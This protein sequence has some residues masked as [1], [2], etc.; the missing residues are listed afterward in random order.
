MIREST[1][2]IDHD[3]SGY[4]HNEYTGYGPP[5]TKHGKDSLHL[6]QLLMN[7]KM[8]KLLEGVAAHF[9]LSRFLSLVWDVHHRHFLLAVI[10]TVL[11]S[12]FNGPFIP[13]TPILMR[14]L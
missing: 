5:Q 1:D 11:V 3:T 10:D 13:W 7:L 2:V 9:L 8:N 12:I 6:Q 4:L 14:I